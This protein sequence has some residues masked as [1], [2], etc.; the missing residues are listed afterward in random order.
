MQDTPKLIELHAA[1]PDRK[2]NY[3]GKLREFKQAEAEGNTALAVEKLREAHDAGC[4]YF[5]FYED[6]AGYTDS[7]LPSDGWRSKLADDCVVVLKS[8]LDHEKFLRQA[9]D[10]LKMSTDGMQPDDL[11]YKRMQMLVAQ[12]HPEKIVGLRQSFSEFQ[13]PTVGFDLPVPPSGPRN[14][15]APG[16]ASSAAEAQ[17]TGAPSPG[18]VG[19]SLKFGNDGALTEAVGLKSEDAKEFLLNQA[20][21]ETPNGAKAAGAV[22]GVKTPEVISAMNQGKSAQPDKKPS[23]REETISEA[24]KQPIKIVGTLLGVVLVTLVGAW[25]S[26]CGI[27]K[28]ILPRTD[29]P[30]ASANPAP[31]KSLP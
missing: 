17:P 2:E 10:R 11:S 16:L 23:F 25:L 22:G 4:R 5:N 12:F 3:M 13:L 21:L 27:V 29:Q 30:P 1:A 20:R 18:L 7:L 24:K 31:P 28:R 19:T 9:A 8:R 14:N 15:P 26:Q 6:L